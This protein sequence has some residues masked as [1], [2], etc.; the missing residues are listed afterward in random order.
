[1]AVSHCIKFRLILCYTFRDMHRTKLT[2]QKIMKGNNFINTDDRVMVL[3]FS[4][5]PLIALYHCIK[6]HLFI[7]NTVRDMLRT[8]LLLQ[9]LGRVITL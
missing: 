1:M 4:A 3:A 9:K 6:F 5:L 8:S 2:L 7:F